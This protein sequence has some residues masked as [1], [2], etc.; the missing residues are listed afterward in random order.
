MFSLALRSWSHRRSHRVGYSMSRRPSAQQ[1]GLLQGSKAGLNLGPAQVGCAAVS[2][3]YNMHGGEGREATNRGFESVERYHRSPRQN[4]PGFT[5]EFRLTGP[6]WVV[7][8]Q[9]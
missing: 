6:H 2:R 3:R 8:L 1:S 7:R 4:R 5:I 9:C